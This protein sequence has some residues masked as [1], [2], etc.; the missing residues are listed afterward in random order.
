MWADKTAWK[1]DTNED[2]GYAVAR[3]ANGAWLTLMISSIE[4]N[5]KRGW[6]EITGTK[7][8]YIMDG[9][10]YE[11]LLPGGNPSLIKGPNPDS[12]G[13]RF[14]QNI[15]DHLVK[16]TP[17][18]ITGEWAR[19]PIHILDLACKSAEKNAALKAKYR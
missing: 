4:A 10:T 17:L 12:E 7:G 19:R 9:G 18:V 3:F 2:E 11:I 15:A 14:Y 6:L 13:W 8:S 16:N 1:A 5:P